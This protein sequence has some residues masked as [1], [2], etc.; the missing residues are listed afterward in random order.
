MPESPYWFG[1]GCPYFRG[2][3]EVACRDTP[4]YE[5]TCTPE[6]VFCIHDDNTSDVEGNCNEAQCPLPRET[7][8]LYQFHTHY[9]A[10]SVTNLKD[11]K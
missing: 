11:V 6:L 10:K 7:R 1:K 8:K 2:L 5:N 9:D 3:W 4:D